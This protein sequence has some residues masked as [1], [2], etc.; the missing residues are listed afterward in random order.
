LPFKF[1]L[2]RYSEGETVTALAAAEA[3]AA[4]LAPGSNGGL[5]ESP[6]GWRAFDN[7]EGAAAVAA[8]DPAPAPA[9]FLPDFEGGSGGGGGDALPPTKGCAVML[10]TGGGEAM[11][12]AVLEV[13]LQAESSAE[14]S[15]S[16]KNGTNDAAWDFEPAMRW[17]SLT[18]VRGAAP[19]PRQN[20][21][22]CAVPAATAAT[23]AATGGADP[24]GVVG[25][26]FVYGGFDGERET[27]DAAILVRRRR[28]SRR[29]GAAAEAAEAV[30]ASWEWEWEWVTLPVAAYSPSPPARSHALAFATPTPS[31]AALAAAA[32]EAVAL[33]DIYVFG[34]YRSGGS[35]GGLRNDLWRLDAATLR[36]S[37]PEMFGDVPPPRR[38]AALAVTS[39]AGYDTAGGAGVNG[40]SGSGRNRIGNGVGGD[41]GLVL[42]HGGCAADGEPL[43]DLYSLHL[44]SLTWTRLPPDSSALS[45]AAADAADALVSDDG[46]YYGGAVQVE[47]R[48]P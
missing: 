38:D 10:L 43:A 11:T 14:S 28:R 33:T 8:A 21:A 2:H 40:S 47:F 3:R 48:L 30:E 12:A 44:A 45:D 16:A 9:V 19:A 23:A 27:N 25:G 5:L 18:A 36:W 13:Q 37:S 31:P 42:V 46:G 32:V 35:S 41:G 1:N 34:G 6:L 15:S 17:T 7:L 4:M 22:V 39:T 20:P 26:V 24:A 29:S